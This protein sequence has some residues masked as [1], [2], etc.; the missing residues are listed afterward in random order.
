MV[1]KSYLFG[2]YHISNK[3]VFKL[4]DSVFYALK[5]VDMVGTEV[6]NNNWQQEDADYYKMKYSYDMLNAGNEEFTITEGTFRKTNPVTK[7]PAF[8]ALQPGAINYFLYRNNRGNEDF[9]E[10]AFLDR[11]IAS[12]GYKL[13][14]KIVGLENY[15]ESAVKGIEAAKESQLE[16]KRSNKKLPD[17]LSY[18]MINDMIFDGYKN[19]SLDMLDSLDRYNYNS[20]AYY[21]IFI[22]DRNYNQ[23]DSM[24]YYIKAGY[25]LFAAVGSAHLPGSEGVIEILRKKGYTVR[26]VTLKGHA[27]DEI[28]NIKKTMYP[29]QLHQYNT[30]D[31][32]S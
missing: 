16:E 32:F 31:D 25:A 23:A 1:K 22:T 7:L 2:T 20:D 10:E 11:F 24:D 17:G 3:G 12:A 8:I 28:E 5:A 29:V 21:K 26:P 27:K 14:K 19:S 15:L 13:G 30:A 6:N 18:N 9:E 4:A